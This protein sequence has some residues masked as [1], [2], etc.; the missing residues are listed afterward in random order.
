[1]INY[2]FYCVYLLNLFTPWSRV[3]LEKLTSL[4]LVKKFPAFYGT[5]R[6]ITTFTN[7]CHLSLSWASSIQSIPPHRTSWTSILFHRVYGKKMKMY[8]VCIYSKNICICW[9]TVELMMKCK[10]CK[11][12]G[13]QFEFGLKIWPKYVY[14]KNVSYHKMPYNIIIYKPC[15]SSSDDHSSQCA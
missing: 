6:F 12:C 8:S 3:L 4:Q 14:N 9:R 7:A 15:M 5:R 11:M 10:L 13:K 1:M 2:F